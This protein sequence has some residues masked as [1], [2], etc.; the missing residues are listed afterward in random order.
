MADHFKIETETWHYNDATAYIEF[1]N[2]VPTRQ[3]THVGERWLSSRQDNDPD[4][5]PLL[6]DQPLQPGEFDEENRITAA[7]FEEVWNRAI[8]YEDAL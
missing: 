5:G 8:S 2:A 4:V 3:V 6:T 7:E 1:T